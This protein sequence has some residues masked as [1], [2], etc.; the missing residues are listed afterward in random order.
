MPRWY[1]SRVSP[2]SGQI[3][4]MLELIPRSRNV[5]WRVV[6]ADNRMLLRCTMSSAWGS[7]DCSEIV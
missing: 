6:Y 1:E 7:M 3:S 5:V 4:S 2:G